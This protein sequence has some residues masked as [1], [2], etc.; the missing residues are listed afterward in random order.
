MMSDLE[1]EH[2]MTPDLHL[3]CCFIKGVGILCA[4][5]GFWSLGPLV[6]MLTLE[7]LVRVSSQE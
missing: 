3:L 6:D 4:L 5:H 2:I 1:H 7:N